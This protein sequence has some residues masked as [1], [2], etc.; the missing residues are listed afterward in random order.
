MAER[1]GFLLLAIGIGA[2]GVAIGAW[3]IYGIITVQAP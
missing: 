1:R 2:A 3:T